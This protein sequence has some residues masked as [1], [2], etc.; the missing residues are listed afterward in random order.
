MGIKDKVRSKKN[1]K[2]RYSI[3]NVSKKYLSK[4]IREFEKLPYESYEMRRP[5]NEPTGSYFHL[6]RQLTNFMMRADDVNSDNYPVRTEITAMKQIP[7]SQVCY[8]EESE[9]K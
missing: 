5:K 2:A 4:I 8:T 7:I 3:G 6:E 9:L 1:T